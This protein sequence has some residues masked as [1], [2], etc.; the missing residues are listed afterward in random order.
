MA[1]NKEISK[2]DI[3]VRIQSAIQTFFDCP[4]E[5]ITLKTVA[6]DIDGWDSLA[7]TVFML[8]LENEFAVKFDAAE[9]LNFNNVSEIV[10]AVISHKC[11]GSIDHDSR[12]A[13]KLKN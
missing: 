6:L 7:H 2:D 9:V 5:A 13:Q 4:D 1:N 10:E 11:H 12:V 8:E 3:F